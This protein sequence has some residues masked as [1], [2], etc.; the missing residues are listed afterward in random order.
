[1]SWENVFYYLTHIFATMSKSIF[2]LFEKIKYIGIVKLHN[3]ELCKACN[4][5]EYLTLLFLYTS[6][7]KR[8][9]C[10]T[11]LFILFCV[12]KLSNFV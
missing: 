8:Y 5:I 12:L 1:M 4:S 3:F 7:N 9:D 2:N 10:Y 6:N 11:K